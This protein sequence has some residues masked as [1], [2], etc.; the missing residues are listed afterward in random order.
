MGPELIWPN[1]ITGVDVV[2]E[3]TG[4]EKS[5]AHTKQ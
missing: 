2:F 4:I 3:D 1:I 5:K